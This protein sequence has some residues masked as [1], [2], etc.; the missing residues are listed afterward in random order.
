MHIYKD[1]SVH[2][3]KYDICIYRSCSKKKYNENKIINKNILH[4]RPQNYKI[5]YNHYNIS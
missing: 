3:Y 1:K 4:L 2:T 5:Y